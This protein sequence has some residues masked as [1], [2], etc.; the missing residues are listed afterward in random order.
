M[1]WGQV[2]YKMHEKRLLRKRFSNEEAPDVTKSFHVSKIKM[3]YKFIG[4]K[5]NVPSNVLEKPCIN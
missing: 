2:T 4:Q 3:E 1:T 5:G